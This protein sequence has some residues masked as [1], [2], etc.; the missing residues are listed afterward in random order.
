MIFFNLADIS[1]WDETDG[2]IEW[3]R[4]YIVQAELEPPS[5]QD[6]EDE[7]A[8]ALVDSSKEA[9]SSSSSSSEKKDDSKE[10]EE[11]EREGFYYDDESIQNLHEM[12]CDM[13]M[14]GVEAI[15]ELLTG[16]MTD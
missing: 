2:T 3:L 1:L 8:H 12:Y 4:E 9:S 7:E 11:E 13:F 16:N 14:T 6:L 10:E 15:E 5:V